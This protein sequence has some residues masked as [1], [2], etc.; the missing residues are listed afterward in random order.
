MYCFIWSEW[1]IYKLIKVILS[2]NNFSQVPAVCVRD[3]RGAFFDPEKVQEEGN[4]PLQSETSTLRDLLPVRPAV[5]L[6]HGYAVQPL[7][8]I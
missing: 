7:E 2:T 8:Y 5:D 1:S 4:L 3:S 6:L